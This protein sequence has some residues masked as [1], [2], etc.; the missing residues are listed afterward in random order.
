MSVQHVVLLGFDPELGEAEVADMRAQV[1][2]WPEAIGGFET[3]ALGAPIST[4]R[5]QGYHYLLY[6]VFPD[7]SELDRYQVHP[8]HQKFARWV[9]DHGGKVLAFDYPLDP[10]TVVVPGSGR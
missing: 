2:S 10:S 6:M 7:E 3:L 5:S 9:V 8:V 4:E 1:T